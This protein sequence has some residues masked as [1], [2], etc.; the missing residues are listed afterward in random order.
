MALDASALITLYRQR[1]AH[2][3]VTANL[4]Y[5]LGFREWAY[6]KRAVAALRLQPG[7]TVVEIGCGTGLNFPLLRQAVGPRGKII[8]VD[9]TDAMLA[10]AARRV[11]EAGWW[12]V[13]LVQADASRYEFPRCVNGVI[14][15][16]AITLVPEFDD[17]VRHGSEALSDGGRFVVFDFKFPSR[18]YARPIVPLA[19]FLTRPFGV[20]IEMASRHPWESIQKYFDQTTVREF[21][22]GMAYV[23][24][25]GGLADGRRRR[26]PATQ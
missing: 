16:L 12:N 7:D 8:G 20:R 24:T 11:D 25:G 6:R 5:L 23:A 1:A 15:T 17:I 26:V 21:Y 10:Q 2:Y 18:W 3:D 14:S 4:Y 9:L 22:L 19:A 13:E